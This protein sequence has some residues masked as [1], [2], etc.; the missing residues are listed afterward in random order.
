MCY[1]VEQ[2]IPRRE[3][4]KR[5]GVSMPEDPRYMPAFLISAFTRPFLPVITLDKPDVIQLFQWGLIPS[6]VRDEKSADQIRNSTINARSETAREK[7]SFRNSMKNKRCLVISHGFFE[8]HTE[9]NKKIPYYIRLKND[10]IFAFAGLFDN[11]VNP[12]TGELNN[13][14]TILTTRANSLLEKI[15][16]LKKRMPVILPASEEEQWISREQ[17]F[18]TLD[19]LLRPFA[20]DELT[21]HT[22]SPR[23]SSRN[24]DIHDPELLKYYDYPKEDTDLFR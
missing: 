21:A 13:T 20:D 18:S 7:P 14:F 1:F 24:V 11:W 2:N 16:N 9:G 19:K 23:I 8:Y 3:L 17:D 6:W 12:S 4:E 10:Q 5:F 22:V 15:H